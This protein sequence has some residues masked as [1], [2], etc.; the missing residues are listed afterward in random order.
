[1]SRRLWDRVR[2]RV[3]G[4]PISVLVL[5]LAAGLAMLAVQH[6]P[7][8]AA[9]NQPLD[10]QAIFR[11]D[12]F[13][14][15][16]LWTDRLRM[17]EVIESSVDPLTA[18]AV[19]LKV[20]V[21]ALP[22]ALVQKLRQNRVPNE[23]ATTV[24]LIKLNAVVGVVGTVQRIGGRDRLT[25]VGIT[26]ALCHSTVD[27][28]LL[29]G[30]G[31]RLDGW[32]NLD[33]DPG[34]IIALS[35]AIPAEAKAVYKS[36]G[37][38]KYDPRFNID[39]LNTPLVL[40][41][42]FGLADVAKETYTGEGPISYWNQYV[43]VTQ[44]GGHGSFSDLRLGINIMQEPDLVAPKLGPLREYQFSLGTPPPPPGSFDPTAAKRGQAVFR[45]A[46]RCITCHIPPLYTDVNLGI[47]H[48]PTDTGMDPAYA[49][50]TTTK[51]YRTTPLRAL[52]QHP[53]YFHDGS[54]ETLHDVVEH[55]DSFL[56]L[57]LIPRQK[58]DLVEFLKSL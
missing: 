7:V 9:Q 24:A 26:C 49:E 1:M 45:G 22:P 31:R 8:T 42:A 50:R 41:P 5:G 55:Y 40:P 47:L 57:R 13:G 36:W 51:K 12:T 48:D 39:G 11:F 6:R 29:P 20:D 16:Q 52:W 25:R 27:D 54:A 14:D 37:P 2:S 23:P 53:P 30:I 3:R 35:P 18:L 10:G 33:L 4:W 32:P 21:E 34:R 46:G 17:H 38:G 58:D 56:D 15:E 19:G 43:A 28:S 44:M